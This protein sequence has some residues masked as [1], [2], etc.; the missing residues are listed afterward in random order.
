MPPDPEMIQVGDAAVLPQ[1]H[2]NR[3]HSRCLNGGA[4]DPDPGRLEHGIERLRE[5][6]ILVIQD[7]LRSCPGLVPT[8]IDAVVQ[9]VE[10]RHTVG[11]ELASV[12]DEASLV[13]RERLPHA[14]AG[15][16][17]TPT[18]AVPRECVKVADVAA[19]GD[20]VAAQLSPPL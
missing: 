11:A 4:D 7:E 12:L 1:P 2:H 14:I 9:V 13:G 19:A 5:A 8:L 15:Q 3:I 18:A 20:V 6:G 16:G 17:L 10:V